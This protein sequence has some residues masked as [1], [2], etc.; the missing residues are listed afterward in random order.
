[1][2]D[3]IVETVSLSALD[4][5]RPGRWR[6]RL[7]WGLLGA[8]VAF[9]LLGPW[10]IAADPLQQNLR[11]V[12]LPPGSAEAVL[13]TDHLGRSMAARLAQ[14]TRLSLWL[15]LLTVASAALP[16]VAL[17]LLAAWAGGWT[18][19]LLTGL[20]DAVM[21]LPGLLLVVMI[22]AF[23]PGGFLPLYL[24]LAVALWVEYFRLARAS[25]R[26]RLQLPD[27]EAARMLGFGRLHIIRRHIL[28]DLWQPLSTL[29]AFGLATVVLAISTLSFVNI[30]VRPPT[31]EWGNMMT[32]LLPYYDEAPLHVLMPAILL[33]ASMFGLALLTDGERS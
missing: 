9:G 1:M 13:G 28:P 20:C 4:E 7:G 2:T 5:R 33:F 25:A 10:L 27:V 32:E 24:G 14:A 3:H 18:D 31:P 22:T 6:R 16:G 29:L 23:S 21:A 15:G 19:R 30:G 12:L 26:T 17:G 11:A 8:V